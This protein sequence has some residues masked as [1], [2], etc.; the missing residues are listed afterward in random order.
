MG[1]APARRTGWRPGLVAVVAL[2]LLAA[3]SDG[4]DGARPADTSTA[5]S[6]ATTS[7]T[8]AP[9]T[10]VAFEPRV[11]APPVA[12][13]PQPDGTP[14]PTDE[15]PE[16]PV[17]GG[18]DAAALQAHLDRSF[19]E[20]STEGNTT[21]AVLVVQHGRIVVERYRPGFGDRATTHPSWSMA[22]SFTQALTG[23]LVA[24]GDLDIYEPAPVPA[25]SDPDDPR[26][27]I[28]TDQLLRMASGLEWKEDYFSTDSDTIAMLFGDGQADMAAYAASKPAAAPPDSQVAYSTGTSN[29][30]SGIIGR[31]VGTGDDYE[32]F[33]DDELLE[34]IGIDPAG[35]DLGWDGAGQLIGGSVFDLNA[36]DYARFGLLYLRGGT[37]DG[38]PI[39]PSTWVDYGRTPTPPPVGWDKYAAHWWTYEDCPGGFRAGGF[40]GQHIVICPTLDLVVVVLSSR[41][42]G[43]DGEVR[44]GLVH[45]FRDARPEA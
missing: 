39:V 35:T 9:T 12:Y 28:T 7:T 26:H 38:R 29:I 42:D 23:I 36:R 1:P 44:D 4:S 34:P 25:W 32:R 45:L 18:V 2:A 5:P 21:D 17:P 13:P 16:G 33:V 30:V 41:S 6:T 11:A 22:K 40:Y 8:L 15:W 20:L 3:C 14:W 10:T 31:I 27:A 24:R 19:G 37:W 43:K